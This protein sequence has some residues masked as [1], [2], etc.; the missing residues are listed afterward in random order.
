MGKHTFLNYLL[1]TDSTYIAPLSD[2]ITKEY[3]ALITVLS[4]VPPILWQ[5][6]SI[7]GT[8]GTITARDLVAY[9][10]GWATLLIGWYQAGLNNTVPQMPGEGFTT[11]DYTGLALHFY[12]KYHCKSLDKQ[13]ALF[14]TVVQ[15]IIAIV[16]HEHRQGNLDALGIWSWCTL[17]SGKQWP[18][19]KWIRVNTSSPYK[20]ARGL[21]K[22]L[23]KKQGSVA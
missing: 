6:K 12:K 23:L 16:E 18:L 19:S 11:W 10:I 4:D 13:L 5:S 21:I 7:N 17:P 3:N 22:T 9:Q 14:H 20:R 15:E 8:G 2:S 1:P